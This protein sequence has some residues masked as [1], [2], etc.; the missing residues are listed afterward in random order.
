MLGREK[1]KTKYLIQ[2]I[3]K[4]DEHFQASPRQ[5][6]EE[7]SHDHDFDHFSSMCTRMEAVN[8]MKR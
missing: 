8:F 7:E 2:E 4:K 3:F 5:D 6:S 1:Q